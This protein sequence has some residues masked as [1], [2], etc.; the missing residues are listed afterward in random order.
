MTR[1]CATRSALAPPT[2]SGGQPAEGTALGALPLA[3]IKVLDLSSII[4]APV[5]ATMLGDFGAEVVKIEEP[6]RGDFMRRSAAEPG[7]RS[8]HRLQDGRN[9]RSITL[10]LR[11][12]EGRA[13]VHRLLPH[14]DAM[15]TN[16][17]PPT[18]ERWELDPAIIR[19][20]HP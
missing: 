12:P 9:K 2:P 14:F 15:V 17:R 5:T 13:I 11:Q 4:A 18:L 6:G 10:D 20:R 16:F 8:L 3:G 19:E 7:G 1:A